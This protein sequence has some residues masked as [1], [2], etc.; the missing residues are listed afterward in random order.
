MLLVPYSRTV[1]VTDDQNR[2]Q[3]RIDRGSYVIFPE[4][5]RPTPISK[6]TN[7]PLGIYRAAIYTATT[8]F[9][10]RFAPAAAMQGV[11]DSS[12]RFRLVAGARRHVRQRQP[13]HS[14]RRRAA[15]RRWRNRD[16]RTDL[17]PQ[18]RC[19]GAGLFPP[20]LFSSTTAPMPTWPA[21]VC[22]ARAVHQR[23][24]GFHVETRLVLTGAERF[25][26]A[27]FAQ[28]PRPPLQATAA[29]SVPRATSRRRT[30]RNRPRPASPSRGASRLS[31]AASRR[32]RT[33][34]AS[35]W[36]SPPGATWP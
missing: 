25:S 23:A 18:S 3:R 6:V 36:A 27:A 17:R 26:V 34:T 19:A 12:Y 11:D 31:R 33:S 15:L 7:R 2:V 9:D 21:G 22:G 5:A 35:T 24:A 14:R 16:A 13:R 32:R 30:R 8:D 1:E 28:T 20:G 4:W 29:M 10:A